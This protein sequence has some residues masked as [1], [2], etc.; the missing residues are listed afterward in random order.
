MCREGLGEKGYALLNND[1]G[2]TIL[3]SHSLYLLHCFSLL[4]INFFVCL[5]RGFFLK[6]LIFVYISTERGKHTIFNS[7]LLEK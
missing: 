1:L 4:G 2:F 7:R 5:C 6:Y 3:E